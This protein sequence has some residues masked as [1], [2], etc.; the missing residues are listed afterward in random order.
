MRAMLGR[1]AEGGDCVLAQARP[2]MSGGTHSTR[3]RR[4]RLALAWFLR[5]LVPPSPEE[6][7]NATVSKDL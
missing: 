6:T 7:D 2:S 5:G 3:D 4:P 1:E